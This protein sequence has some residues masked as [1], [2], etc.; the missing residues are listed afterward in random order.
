MS[1]AVAKKTSIDERLFVQ[2]ISAVRQIEASSQIEAFHRALAA[3][4]SMLTRDEK[5]QSV[6]G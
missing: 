6:I 5:R 3:C 4:A 2:F 1:I